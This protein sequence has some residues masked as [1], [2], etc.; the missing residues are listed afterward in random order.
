MPQS[1]FCKVLSLPLALQTG[2]SLYA[3]NSSFREREDL[4]KLDGPMRLKLGP[5]EAAARG[6][7]NAERVLAWNGLGEV[8]FQLE[9]TPD[10]P[11]GIAVA[12][13]VYWLEQAFGAR[14]VNALTSQRL[15]DEGSGSTF[16]DNRIDVRR[17]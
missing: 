10:V 1:S 2:V 15:T 7:L 4:I 11:K 16:Y 17:R 13:G 3:L 12:E 6:L 14:T 5:D 8:E 9:I